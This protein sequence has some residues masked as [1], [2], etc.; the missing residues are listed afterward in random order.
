M[1]VNAYRVQ[2][3]Y[4]ASKLREAGLTA[5]E[6]IAAFSM[7]VG[8]SVYQTV[9]NVRIAVGWT[10][11]VQ[12]PSSASN[13]VLNFWTT[14]VVHGPEEVTTDRLR[15]G[16][17]LRMACDLSPSTCVWDG[18]SSLVFELSYTNAILGMSIAVLQYNF[19]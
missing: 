12:A 5:G 6:S 7:Q 1:S 8:S 19:K 13:S 9:S 17:W 15:E 3:L 10:T 4:P 11:D 14:T 2:S 18:T 16:S